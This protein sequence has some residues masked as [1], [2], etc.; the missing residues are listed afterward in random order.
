[1]SLWD[2]PMA[3]QGIFFVGGST[4]WIIY[5]LYDLRMPFIKSTLCQSPTMLCPKKGF[6]TFL[7]KW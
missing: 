2:S 7:V 5:G 1:M 4:I 6:V 3:H